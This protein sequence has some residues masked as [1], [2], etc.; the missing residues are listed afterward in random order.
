MAEGLKCL[1]LLTHGVFVCLF[2]PDNPSEM[3]QLNKFSL[4]DTDE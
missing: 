4:T 1:K 2:T 3:S